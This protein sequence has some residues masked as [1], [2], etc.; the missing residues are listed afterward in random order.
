MTDALDGVSSPENP[1][2]VRQ[3]PV[4]SYVSDVRICKAMEGVLLERRVVPGKPL[5]RSKA[6]IA[7]RPGAEYPHQLSDSIT[8]QLHCQTAL[9]LGKREPQTQELATGR[10]EVPQLD[11]PQLFKA[12]RSPAPRDEH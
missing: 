12:V 5:L 8:S 11:Q 1:S 7:R 3:Q 10:W 4:P 9:I 6:L 2:G